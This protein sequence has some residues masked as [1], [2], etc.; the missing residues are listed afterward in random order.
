MKKSVVEQFREVKLKKTEEIVS[1]GIMLF[2]PKV[3]M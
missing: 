1:S 2:G 3:L